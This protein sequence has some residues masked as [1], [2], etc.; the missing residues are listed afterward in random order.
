MNV[1][2][3][4]VLL[5]DDKQERLTGEIAEIWSNCVV[6]LEDIS[7]IRECVDDKNLGKAVVHFKHGDY[8]IID[9]PFEDVVE[10]WRS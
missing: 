6:D 5:F 7:A 1:I 8:F 9:K 4:K 2:E 3:C 10:K